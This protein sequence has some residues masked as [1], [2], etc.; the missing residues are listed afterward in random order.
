MPVRSIALASLLA[1]AACGANA[2]PAEEVAEG[3]RALGSEDH[4]Q[5]LA[6]FESALERIGADAAH[7]EFLA[8]KLGSIEAWTAINP[9]RAK[10]EF[11]ELARSQPSRVTDRDFSLVGSRLGEAGGFEQAI[12]VV[13]A[14]IE[15]HPES[16]H[17]IALRDKLGDQ[18][19]AAGSEGALETLRGIGYLGE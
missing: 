3:Y 17:L 13:S 4:A 16:P 19:T 18:A 11:L 6:S 10:D 7:P 8:A 2:T 5:A 12:D 14:G 15:A 1:H 9:E